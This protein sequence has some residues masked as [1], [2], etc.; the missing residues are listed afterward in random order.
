MLFIWIYFNSSDPI[1]L[2][3]ELY[4]EI[5]DNNGYIMEKEWCDMLYIQKNGWNQIQMKTEAIGD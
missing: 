1:S 2:S 5:E 4:S 3:L